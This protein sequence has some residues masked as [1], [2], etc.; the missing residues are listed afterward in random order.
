MDWCSSVLPALIG[1]LV[2]LAGLAVTL[3]VLYCCLRQPIFQHA[4]KDALF[5]V[6]SVVMVFAVW[7]ACIFVLNNTSILPT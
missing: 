5:W 6:L 7:Y 1:A 3:V 4:A 2:Y